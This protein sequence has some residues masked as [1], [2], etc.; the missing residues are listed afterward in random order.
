[1]NP[2]ALLAWGMPPAG[3]GMFARDDVEPGN[4][5]HVAVNVWRFD[6][7]EQAAQARE[8]GAD[9]WSFGGPDHWT[10]ANWRDAIAHVRATRDEIG[11]VG[12]IAEYEDEW[13]FATDDER[14]AYGAALG[15]LALEMRVGLTF[16][17]SMRGLAVIASAAGLGIFGMLQEHGLTSTSSPV[18]HRWWSEAVAIFGLRLCLAFA[19]WRSSSLL[20]ESTEYPPY[21]AALPRCGGAWVWTAANGTIPGYMRDALRTYEPGGSAVGTVLEAALRALVRPVVAVVVALVALFALL[22]GTAWR[23]ARA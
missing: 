17:A 16:Y 5:R 6:R 1:M 15:E 7:R 23:L 4:W 9:V 3:L 21:L 22:V 10:P 18:L 2:A 13:N 12:V 14:R 20:D 11:A 8:L 19:A